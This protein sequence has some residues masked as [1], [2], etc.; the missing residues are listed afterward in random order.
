MLNKSGVP[1]LFSFLFFAFKVD[2]IQWGSYLYIQLHKS[3]KDID[4]AI[5]QMYNCIQ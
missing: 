1:G 3:S 5:R 2:N 4:I